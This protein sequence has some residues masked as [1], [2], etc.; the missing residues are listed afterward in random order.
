MNTTFADIWWT[1]IEKNIENTYFVW[2]DDVDTLTATSQFYYRIYNP[3]LWVEF[4]TENVTGANENNIEQWNHIHT[5]T[6]IPNNPFTRNGGDYGLFAQVINQN[7]LQTLYEHYASADHHK[8]S[9]MNF[10][11]KI[12]TVD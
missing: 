7:G 12:K 4:N 8:A 2:I 3:Y 1:D 9:E 11:Y 10:D 5:I 6:R